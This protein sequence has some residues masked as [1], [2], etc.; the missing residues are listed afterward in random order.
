M[1]FKDWF[2]NQ[3]LTV[4][5]SKLCLASSDFRKKTCIRKTL[6]KS[7][8]LAI[9]EKKDCYTISAHYQ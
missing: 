2:M 7:T 5:L 8:V 4:F 9:H 3:I 1:S 6:T